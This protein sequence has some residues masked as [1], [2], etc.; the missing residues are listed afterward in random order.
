MAKTVKWSDLEAHCLCGAFFS[1][2]AIVKT[3]LGKMTKEIIAALRNLEGVYGWQITFHALVILGT[4]IPTMVTHIKQ[5]WTRK[6]KTYSHVLSAHRTFVLLFYVLRV[7][8]IHTILFWKLGW[9][10]LKVMNLHTKVTFN[11]GSWSK[12]KMA[13]NLSSNLSLIKIPQSNGPVKQMQI[14]HCH[15]YQHHSKKHQKQYLTD[16]SPP[17]WRARFSCGYK[18]FLFPQT[19]S[20]P[21][22]SSKLQYW[23]CKVAGLLSCVDLWPLAISS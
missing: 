14:F 5:V 23:V 6:D 8:V 17:L 13:I 12:H 4:N 1:A 16:S 10:T 7:V 19:L 15:G 2:F 18:T 9:K 20:R 11:C 22:E 3:K 21:S